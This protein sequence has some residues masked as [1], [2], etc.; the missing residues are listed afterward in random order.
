MRHMRCEGRRLCWAERASCVIVCRV[1]TLV[2]AHG[3]N[4]VAPPVPWP[5]RCRPPRERVELPAGRGGYCGAGAW[6]DGGARTRARALGST[7]CRKLAGASRLGE[8]PATTECGL[9][10]RPSS[11]LPAK[12]RGLR[13]R[14]SPGM[15]SKERARARCRALRPALLCQANSAASSRDIRRRRRPGPR[16]PGGRGLLGRNM[17]PIVRMRGCRR[18]RRGTRVAGA[19]EHDAP[20]GAALCAE[21]TTDRRPPNN[22][23]TARLP[24]RELARLRA[25]ATAFVATSDQPRSSRVEPASLSG[26]RAAQTRNGACSNATRSSKQMRHEPPGPQLA[27]R[28]QLW[29]RPGADSVQVW[30]VGGNFPHA[31]PNATPT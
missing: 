23:P 31:T 1:V 20:L 14:G 19:R 17:A 16:E 25:R 21:P 22:P 4:E 11:L 5:S 10:R 26:P 12:H 27:E 7:L 9:E 24:N 8:R 13:S 28:G 30:C 15:R 29:A 6:R 18:S 2:R 3:H